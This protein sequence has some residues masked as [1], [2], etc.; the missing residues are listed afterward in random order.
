MWCNAFRKHVECQYQHAGRPT[1]ATLCGCRFVDAVPGLGD[2]EPALLQARRGRRGRLEGAA[3]S[4]STAL[5]LR[6]CTP[7]FAASGW[8]P[9]T[10]PATYGLTATA[11]RPA[12]QLEGMP[13][14]RFNTGNVEKDE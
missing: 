13:H 1:L 8:A 6:S 5:A 11:W 4:H 14:A 3:L 9:R 12:R 7:R 2:F 10:F